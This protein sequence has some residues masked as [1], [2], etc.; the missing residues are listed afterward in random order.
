MTILF[1]TSPLNKKIRSTEAYW[2]YIISVKHRNMAGREN[3]AKDTLSNPDFIRRTKID[4]Q[5]FYITRQLENIF[6]A[7][8]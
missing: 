7:L 1:A 5:I 6:G 8:L 3:E 4:P 2:E